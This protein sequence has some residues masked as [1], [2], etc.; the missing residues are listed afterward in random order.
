MT[1]KRNEEKNNERNVHTNTYAQDKTK[2]TLWQNENEW[3]MIHV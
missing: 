2:P 1:Y 3:K